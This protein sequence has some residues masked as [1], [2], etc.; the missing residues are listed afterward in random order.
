MESVSFLLKCQTVSVKTADGII[1][2]IKDHVSFDNV[3]NY[4]SI[5]ININSDLF[6]AWSSNW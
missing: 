2:N 5:A 1:Q 6:K 4:F 3:F